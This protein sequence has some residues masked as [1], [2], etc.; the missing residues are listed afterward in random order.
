MHQ[1]HHTAAVD[2]LHVRNQSRTYTQV[3]DLVPS[4]GPLHAIHSWRG[5]GES[6]T[7]SIS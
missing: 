5:R 1:T 7:P 6:S 3:L 2:G 4:G